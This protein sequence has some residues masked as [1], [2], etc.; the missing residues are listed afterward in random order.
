[1]LKAKK[2]LRDSYAAKLKSG[3]KTYRGLSTNSTLQT[4]K[5]L[6]ANRSLR[7]SYAQKIKEGEKEAPKAKVKMST[8]KKCMNSIFTKDLNRCVITGDTRDIHVHHIFGASNKANSEKYGFLIPLRADWH[9][10]S[11]YGIHFNKKLNLE[12]KTKCQEYWLSHYGTK[13]EF[14]RIFGKWWVAQDILKGLGFFV[15]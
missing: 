11:D 10:M 9:D 15:E 4:R 5:T 6:T 3:E 14:I 2:S 13:E 1:M 8:P 12:Y 7:D